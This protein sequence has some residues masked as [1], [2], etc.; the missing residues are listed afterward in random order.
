MVCENLRETYRAAVAAFRADPEDAELLENYLQAK[1]AYERCLWAV[2]RFRNTMKSKA[3]L[4]AWNA[5]NEALA[6]RDLWRPKEPVPTIPDD[7]RVGTMINEAGTRR[8]RDALLDNPRNLVALSY[9]IESTLRNAR[10]AL[11]DDEIFECCL[12]VLD[13]PA[14]L[15]QVAGGQ[16]PQAVQLLSPPVMKA[17]AERLNADRLRYPETELAEVESE[18]VAIVEQKL[19]PKT[20]NKS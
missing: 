15:S 17:V 6:A 2:E 18:S 4:D 12:Y 8:L 14:Y 9:A 5:V 10:I 11:A 3:A 7:P 19:S 1:T 16:I 13:K 20:E